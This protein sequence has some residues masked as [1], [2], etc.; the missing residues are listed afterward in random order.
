LVTHL[1][2][3]FRALDLVLLGVDCS[4]EQEDALG[5]QQAP[6]CDLFVIF[7]KP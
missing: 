3:V 1:V 5:D 2:A 4:G 7:K 6:Q